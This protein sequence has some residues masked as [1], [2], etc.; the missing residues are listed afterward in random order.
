MIM[1]L[2][3]KRRINEFF[4]VLLL[5]AADVISCY[6]LRMSSVAHQNSCLLPKGANSIWEPEACLRHCS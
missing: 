2:V 5:Y 1:M 4:H 3:T 6:T